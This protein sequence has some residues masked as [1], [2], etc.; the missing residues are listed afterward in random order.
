VALLAAGRM[1]PAGLA[2]WAHR[3]EVADAGY[4]FETRAAL[5]LSPAQERTFRAAP[6]AWAWFQGRPPGFRRTAIHWVVSAKREETRARRLAQLIASSSP[7][8]P[9]AG[10]SRS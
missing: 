9:R 10:P 6:A 8:R 2:A 4:S 5:K 3:P 1:A 7:A